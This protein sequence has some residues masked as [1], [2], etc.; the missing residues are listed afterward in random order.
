MDREQALKQGERMNKAQLAQVIV[1][2]QYNLPTMP[3]AD[4]PRI[5]IYSRPRRD[6]L[7]RQHALAVDA[8]ISAG[9]DPAY[10]GF[11]R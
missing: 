10:Q 6:T 1:M 3:A 4:D 11:L 5:A 7:V 8:L 9:R 2:A